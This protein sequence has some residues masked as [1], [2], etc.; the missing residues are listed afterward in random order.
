MILL[1]TNV[2]SEPLQQS[3][4]ARVIEW[5]DAQAIETL[6]L[7][8]ITVAELR[9]G[10]A[11]LPAGKRKDRLA[12]RL[13]REILPLFTERVLP[14]DLAASQAYADLMSTARSGG[15]AI[16]KA[17]GL[18]AAIAASRDLAVATRDTAPFLAAGL[19]VIDPWAEF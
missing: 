5:I 7:S 6:H 14:F 16:G 4:N 10:V 19:A 12:I 11:V 3:A 13:E 17:D 9:Y 2:V 18:I 15:K 8:A 1:D